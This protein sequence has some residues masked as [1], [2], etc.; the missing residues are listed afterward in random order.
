MTSSRRR[1]VVSASALVLA[2]VPL[3]GREAASPD[4]RSD[5]SSSCETLNRL[6]KNSIYDAR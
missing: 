1:L 2:S 6:L 4:D 5:A 3:F